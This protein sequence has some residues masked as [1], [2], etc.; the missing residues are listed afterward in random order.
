M[1]AKKILAAAAMAFAATGASAMSLDGLAGS[2]TI[3]LGGLTTET[4]TV[5]SN[6]ANPGLCTAAS[7]N[8][9]TWGVGA[10]TTITS[11]QNGIWNAGSTD[12]YYLYYMLYGIADLNTTP[13]GANG[14][15]LYNTG[16][17]FGD[18]DGKI[19]LDIYRT[20]TQIASIDQTYDAKPG[21]RT[22]FSTYSA[23][24]GLEKYLAVEFAPGVTADDPTT[25]GVDESQ[26]SLFQNVNQ[27]NLGN[28]DLSGFG[29]FIA[30]VVG[31]TAMTKWDTDTIGGHDLDGIFTL[32]SNGPYDTPLTPI[33]G[34]KGQSG[35]C[36]AAQVQSGVCFA[37]FINDPVRAFAIPEPGSLAIFGLGLAGLAALRRRKQK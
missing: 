28:S 1:N 20:K 6:Q 2:L 27:L 25:V 35:T 24:T 3:K 5:S 13:G 8:E 15:N 17:T 29:T 7:C 16:S 22:G 21:D 34:T 19:H 33:N 23:F 10:I 18:G 36:T 14:N 30:D 9:T 37:G 32:R 11:V 12:G 26:T 31:G 4:N